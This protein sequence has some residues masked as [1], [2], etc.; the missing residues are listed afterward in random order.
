MSAGSPTW[1]TGMM[2]FVRSVIARSAAPGSRLY[3][4]GS[5]SAKTGVAPQCQTEFAVAMN[6]SEGTMTS[7]PG[8]TPST[9]RASCSA[10]VQLVVATA[11]A[12]PTRSAKACSNSRTFGPC[13][14]QPDAITAATSSPSRPVRCGLANGI[15]M[16]LR[17]Q[18]GRGDALCAP[19]VD[20]S[21][22]PVF[23]PDL[24]LEAQLLASQRRVGQ[25]ARHLVDA[26]L[27]AELDLEVL[28]AHDLQKQA[29]EL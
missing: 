29:R 13:E 6:D 12:A 27:G 19:P 15:C 22:Q 16:A 10:V 18:R 28:A 14:T 21:P 1:W 25:A 23:E 11:S 3:V 24:G 17:S 20:E 2:T 26:A 8:P 9:Y 5:T 4:A 7:S